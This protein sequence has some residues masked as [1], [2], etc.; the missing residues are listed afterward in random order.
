[1]SIIFSIKYRCQIT[2]R[3]APSSGQKFSKF[4]NF[5]E[6]ISESPDFYV[7]NIYSPTANEW[8]LLF[9]IL[10]VLFVLAA[11]RGLLVLL[12]LVFATHF[13]LW[14]ALALSLER[15]CRVVLCNEMC[16]CAYYTIFMQ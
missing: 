2:G 9:T 5:L 6:V 4:S 1:M 7:H 13:P 16:N 12:C 11:A 15:I 10:H 8:I 14:A 3:T